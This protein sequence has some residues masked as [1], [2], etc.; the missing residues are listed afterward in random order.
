MTRPTFDPIGEVLAAVNA[1]YP[2]LDIAVDWVM[3]EDE[4]APF[5][6]CAFDDSGRLLG[7][8]IN[9]A[10]PVGAVAEIIGHE[11]AHAVAGSDADHGPAWEA[12]FDRIRD[13]YTRR[14]TE[15][16]AAGTRL[17]ELPARAGG[18]G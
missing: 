1:L 13:E 2:D 6:E 11:V 5:G 15:K 7:I 18:V 16:Q 9:A 10:T 14:V 17:A 12:V 8:E 4:G 3:V